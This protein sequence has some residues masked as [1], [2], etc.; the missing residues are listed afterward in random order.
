GEI[1]RAAPSFPQLANVCDWQRGRC[2]RYLPPLRGR[3]R[4]LGFGKAKPLEFARGGDR[5]TLPS[6]TLPPEHEFLAL[7]PPGINL[8]A[9][10]MMGG[11]DALPAAGEP[12]RPCARH[13]QGPNQGG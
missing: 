4:I 1:G 12:P 7:T 11:T 13:A 2:R 9:R 6:Q 8:R 3:K 10:G 5:I